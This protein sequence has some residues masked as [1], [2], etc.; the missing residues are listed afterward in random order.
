MDFLNE[1]L[2]KFCVGLKDLWGSTPKWPDRAPIGCRSVGAT[3]V[4]AFGGW[5]GIYP[6][7]CQKVP[8][9][10]VLGTL[11]NTTRYYIR[12]TKEKK[13]TVQNTYKLCIGFVGVENIYFFEETKTKSI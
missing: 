10:T 12:K 11:K 13:K 9:G 1:I 8:L 5:V 6:V 3:L 2:L 7:Y 4:S